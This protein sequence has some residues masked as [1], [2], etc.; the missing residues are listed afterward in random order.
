[1]PN[2]PLGPLSSMVVLRDLAKSANLSKYELVIKLRLA[3]C[4]FRVLLV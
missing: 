2:R 4:W 1:M 3:E